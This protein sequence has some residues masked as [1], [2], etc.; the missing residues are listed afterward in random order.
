MQTKLYFS[1]SLDKARSGHYIR[2]IYIHKKRTLTSNYVSI[3]ILQP[4]FLFLSNFMFENETLI[5]LLNIP[6]SINQF[7]TI[8]KAFKR[9]NLMQKCNYI[10]IKIEYKLLGTMPKSS[11]N[12][13]QVPFSSTRL[14]TLAI[15]NVLL[16]IC[17]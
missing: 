16:N 15:F 2:F 12:I 7:Q 5:K 3:A 9:Y 4:V 10:K 17:I 6:G 11:K 1:L 13:K 8:A 14:D